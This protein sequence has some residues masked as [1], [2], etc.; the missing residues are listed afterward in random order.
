MITLNIDDFGLSS[1]GEDTNTINT[2]ENGG[3][4]CFTGKLVFRLPKIEK[5]HGQYFFI[6]SGTFPHM[7]NHTSY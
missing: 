5:K 2:V 4:I 3:T 1:I 7:V 6:D